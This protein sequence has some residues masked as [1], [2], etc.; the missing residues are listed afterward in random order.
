MTAE[1]RKTLKITSSERLALKDD[2]FLHI[3]FIVLAIVTG[4]TVG[5]AIA[6]LKIFTLLVIPPKMFALLI[7]PAAFAFWVALNYPGLALSA[8]VFIIYTNLS[9]VMVS[10]WNLPSIA[11]PIVAFLSV[12][13]LIR[14]FLFRDEVRGLQLPIILIGMYI[15]IGMFTLVYAIN[16]TVG[17]ATLIDGLKDIYFSV[18]I[19]AFIQRPKTLKLVIW[20]LLFAGILMSSVSLYQQFTGTFLNQYW[21]FGQ[22]ITSS[23]GT[24]YR[25]GG[26]IGDPNYYAM[27]LVTLISLAIDRSLHEKSVLLRI[28]AGWVVAACTLTVL[29]TYSRGGF[30]ALIG[31]IIFFGYRFR[32]RLRFIP[33]VLG[34]S[35]VFVVFQFLPAKYTDRVSTLLSFFPQSGSNPLADASIRG[36]TS[37]MMAAFQMFLD[38]PIVGVGI[39]NYNTN[40]SAYSRPM[41][42]DRTIGNRYAHDLYLQIAAERGLLGLSAFAILVFATF[43]TLYSAEIQLTRAKMEEYA[44]IAAAIGASL[45]GYLIASMF[46][47]DSYFRY[48]WVLIGIAWSLPQII[49]VEETDKS[50]FSLGQ[51]AIDGI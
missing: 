51:D 9:P 23:T 30:I 8:F 11:Q 18:L 26:P 3:F 32:R 38:H 2:A 37:Q 50:K 34:V 31:V 39:A 15:L 43:R 42:I 49:P 13:L 27:F 6:T 44:S 7:I 48:F 46:L 40:Y 12:V 36:R 28:L 1:L 10:F 16:F 4:A 47:H 19:V 29:Y 33:V 14:V 20:A 25:L 24:G 22:G 41:G 35:I 45:V 5:V 17:Y 21:G